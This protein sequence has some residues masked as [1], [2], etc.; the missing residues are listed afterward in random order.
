M[1]RGHVYQCRRALPPA[2]RAQTLAGRSGRLGGVFTVENQ[3]SES[4]K[5]ADEHSNGPARRPGRPMAD[6]A[7]DS[8]C[9][10]NA[11]SDGNMALTDGA[12]LRLCVTAYDLTV[13]SFQSVISGSAA[14]LLSLFYKLSC[15]QSDDV[16]SDGGKS[17]NKLQACR[18]Q[19]W[20]NTVS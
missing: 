12:A 5:T 1:G 15:R 2:S 3:E 8:E 13:C 4:E 7:T 11:S 10:P 9:D 19:S 20:Y 14:V 16:R 6:V 17:A 18:S